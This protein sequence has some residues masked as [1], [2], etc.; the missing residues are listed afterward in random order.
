MRRVPAGAS[1]RQ[2]AAAGVE[3]L[4]RPVFFHPL[5]ENPD[6]LRLLHVAHRHLVGAPV[7]F[8]AQAV[9]LLRAGPPL[10][11]A[12]HDHRPDRALL[13]PVRAGGVLD[14]ADVVDHFLERLGHQF[15]HRRRVVAL[16]EVGRVAV[17]A[18]ERV[19]LLA[20]NA[21]EHRRIGDLVAVEMQDR[22]HR[23]VA[24]RIEELVGVPARRH[25]AGF[26]LAVADHAGDDQVRIVEGRAVGVRHRIAELAA[27]VDGARRLRRNVARNAAGERELGEEALHPLLVLRHV[28]IDLAVGALQ[29]GVGDQRRAAMARAGDVDH[30]EVVLLDQPVEMNVDEVEAGRR[31][32]V[33]KQARL[34]MLLGQRR[35]QKRIVEQI[36]LPDRQIIGGPPIGVQK[37][38]LVLRQRVRHRALQCAPPTFVS[39]PPALTQTCCVRRLLSS[40]AGCQA[41]KGIALNRHSPDHSVAAAD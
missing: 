37:R 23:A 35:L 39:A 32:P 24:H 17:A 8:F 22:E 12:H 30:V 27:L 25:R 18:K 4:A 19:E 10:R 21:R 20:R 7:A 3:Q 26:G 13:E 38:A 16:D 6:V 2:E 11:R 29:I 9:D 28:G 1:L 5:L 41:A 40:S 36:D 15:V 34:D 33:A 14:A 31:A